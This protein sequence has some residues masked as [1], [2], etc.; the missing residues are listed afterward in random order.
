MKKRIL[1][2]IGLLSIAFIILP[3]INNKKLLTK[4]FD[5]SHLLIY[6]Y[7]DI[8]Y[9]VNK[10]G[11][12]MPVININDSNILK[13]NKEISLIYSVKE[14]YEYSYQYNVSENIL[15]LLITI[16]RTEPITNKLYIDYETYNIDLKKLTILTNEDI[17]DLFEIEEDDLRFFLSNKFMNYYLELIEN[18]Y[19]NQE[20]CDYSCFI[21]NCKFIDF[22]YDNEYYINNNHLE[23]FKY[24]NIYTKYK[25][26][27]YFSEKSFKFTIK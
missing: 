16:K 25:Y 9:E 8:V 27:N 18:N 7:A 5:Y 17:L 21:Q 14:N 4:D 10:N 24:F 6:D 15:S 11:Y 12:Q 2:L 1:V 26:E 19:I 3:I 13:I 23:L 22:L 20:E